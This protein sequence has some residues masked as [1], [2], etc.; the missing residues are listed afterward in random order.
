MKINK[1]ESILIN[2]IKDN[3][4]NIKA[5]GFNLQLDLILSLTKEQYES[6]NINFHDINIIFYLILFF[7]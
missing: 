3:I 4:K 6:F 2:K 5:I 7:L 1:Y